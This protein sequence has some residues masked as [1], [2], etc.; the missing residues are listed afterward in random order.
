MPANIRRCNVCH[1]ILE[2]DEPF[3]ACQDCGPILKRIAACHVKGAQKFDPQ[4]ESRVAEHAA[5]IER[6]LASRGGI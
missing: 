3:S 4:R 6:D 5:R 1:S 2:A